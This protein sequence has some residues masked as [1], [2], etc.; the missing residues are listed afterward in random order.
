MVLLNMGYTFRVSIMILSDFLL[1]SIDPSN[2]WIR[3]NGARLTLRMGEWYWID[4]M[5]NSENPVVRFKS[6]STLSEISSITSQFTSKYLRLS[7]KKNKSNCKLLLEW[8]TYCSEVSWLNSSHICVT[9]NRNLEFTLSYL[10]FFICFLPQ[11]QNQNA[12]IH[13]DECTYTS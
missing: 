4:K 1:R 10:S 9:I 6:E 13:L 2:K 5:I 11:Q 3:Q 8:K 7:I 12:H